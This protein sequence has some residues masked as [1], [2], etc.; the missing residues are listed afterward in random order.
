MPVFIPDDRP[1]VEL[2]LDD[3]SEMILSPIVPE[4]VGLIEEGLERLSV[5]SRFTRFG[6]GIAHL[7]R[8]ELEY[9][10]H[11][12]QRTHVAWG[13]LVDG[14]VAG[15]GRY[16]ATEDGCSEVA[17]TVVDEYQRRGV[18][19]ALLGVLAAVARADGVDE[20]CF[21]VVPGNLAVE[22]LV[23]GLELHPDVSGSLLEGSVRIAD[24]PVGRDEDEM[25]RVMDAC[26]G[27]SAWRPGG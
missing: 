22:H 12:D 16:V 11:V 19:S 23:K 15:V 5:E 21:E 14:E 8:G 10:T 7:S 6:Q 13:A 2:R 1:R 20:F 18:G 26:R 17:I 24:F 9:L 27:Q 25:V 4:D 3:D